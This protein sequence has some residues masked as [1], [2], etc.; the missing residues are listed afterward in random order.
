M[1]FE[2]TRTATPKIALRRDY[3]LSVKNFPCL[4]KTFS[5]HLQYRR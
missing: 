5:L 4:G 3:V 2:I 1:T